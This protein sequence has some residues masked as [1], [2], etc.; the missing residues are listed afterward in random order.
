M[1]KFFYLYDRIFESNRSFTTEHVK[2]INIPG[3]FSLNCQIPGFSRIPGKVATLS[4]KLF[5]LHIYFLM[6]FLCLYF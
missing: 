2:I 1:T 3:F 6:F 5:W 4:F